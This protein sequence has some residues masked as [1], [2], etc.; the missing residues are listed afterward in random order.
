MKLLVLLALAATVTLSLAQQSP[1]PA[2]ASAAA[3]APAYKAKSPKL[4]RAQLDALLAKPEGVVI[5]DVRRPD[6]ITAIGGF[7]AYLNIQA[8]ELDKYLGFIP[9]DR[10]VVAVSNHAGRGGNAADL[11]ASKGFNVAGAVGAQD[12][13]AEGGTLTRIKPPSP[14]AAASGA[15]AAVAVQQ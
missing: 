13:E 9:R 5:V 4:S 3:S 6:E 12:Y 7:P 8:R 14:R 15:S 2:A 1:T 10:A 11:L